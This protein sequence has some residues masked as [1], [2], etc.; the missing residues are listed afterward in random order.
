M[1]CLRDDQLQL[2]CYGPITGKSRLLVKK[3]ERYARKSDR[4]L[5]ITKRNRETRLSAG[6]I[7]QYGFEKMK[8]NVKDSEKVLKEDI[9]E[10]VLQSIDVAEVSEI[11]ET[12]EPMQV[13]EHIEC[14]D[15]NP[16]RSFLDLHLRVNQ[17]SWRHAAQRAIDLIEGI[18][19][20]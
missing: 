9:P 1:R 3:D 5:S 10:E 17:R 7:L 12:A 20:L 19:K 8:P 14:M 15:G 2:D 13:A 11:L 6:K 18:K 4:V 16:Y